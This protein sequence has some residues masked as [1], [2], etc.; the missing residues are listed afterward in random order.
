[1][2]KWII[3]MVVVA[4]VSGYVGQR[5]ERFQYDDAC[6]DFGGE[7]R[8]DRAGLCNFDDTTLPAMP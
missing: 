1:M 4:L 3:V 2:A 7:I 8:T 5:F 6:L